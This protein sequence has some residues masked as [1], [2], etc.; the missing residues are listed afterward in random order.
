MKTKS[1]K[2]A[3]EKVA[4]NL[5]EEVLLMFQRNETYGQFAQRMW[6]LPYRQKELTS[7]QLYQTIKRMKKRGWLKEKK[8][9]DKVYYSLSREGKAQQQM[10]KVQLE[11]RKRDAQATIILFDIPE[12]KSNF[13]HFLRRFLLRNGFTLLQESV[14]ITPY[15]LSPNFFSVLKYMNLLQYITIIKGQVYYH[16]D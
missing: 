15:K 11:G 8:V 3:F 4:K 2:R 1:F 7:K 10:L 9:Q 5:T 6:G 14:F 12:T 13:R 16:I